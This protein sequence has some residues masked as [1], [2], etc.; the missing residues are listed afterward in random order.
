MA[1]MIFICDDERCIGCSSCVVACKAG[2]NVPLGAFRRI[3]MN[4][5]EG[6]PE[7]R[8]STNSCRH[9]DE[10]ECV[11]ACPQNAISKRKDGIVQTNKEKCV[12]CQ[13]CLDVCPY[14]VPSFIKDEYGFYSHQEKCT[15]CAGGPDVENFSE[16]EK[17]LYGQNRIAE[18]K[19]PLCASFCSTKAL[20]AGDKDVVE[21]IYQ[22]RVKRRKRNKG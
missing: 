19:P 20:L 22:E 6:T 1:Q 3:I 21:K 4:Y 9:C 12:S 17:V 18:G 10:P 14:D 7:E 2:H 11:P 15:F 8:Y 5:R 13:I 16:K